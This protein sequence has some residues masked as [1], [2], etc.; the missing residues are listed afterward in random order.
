MLAPGSF[1]HPPECLGCLY[2]SMENGTAGIM[3]IEYDLHTAFSRMIL[4][5]IFTLPSYEHNSSV[6]LFVDFL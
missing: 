3:T 6:H 1:A 4:V 2:Q 5:I